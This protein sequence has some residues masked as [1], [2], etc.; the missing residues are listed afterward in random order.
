[1]VMTWRDIYNTH[2][3]THALKTELFLHQFDCMFVCPQQGW[4][5]TTDK[6][7]QMII[8]FTTIN[9]LDFVRKSLNQHWIYEFQNLL[10]ICVF[11][12][13]APKNN[14]DKFFV[15]TFLNFLTVYFVNKVLDKPIEAL[16]NTFLKR[17]MDFL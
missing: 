7:K 13:F 11:A 5:H 9:H 4:W 16:I 14:F 15:P 2:N 6:E 8:V 1:M 12:I 17:G 10:R 3:T